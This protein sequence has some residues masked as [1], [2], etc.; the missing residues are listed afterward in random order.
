MRAMVC[1]A[2]VGLVAVGA[3]VAPELAEARKAFAEAKAG[4]EG[5]REEAVGKAVAAYEGELRILLA[6]VRQRGDLDYVTAIQG[7][8]KRLETDRSAPSKPAAKRME[9][10]R[11]AQWGARQA[12][13]KAGKE[14]DAKVGKLVAEYTATL[15]ALEKRFVKDNRIEDAKMAREEREGVAAQGRLKVLSGPAFE[16]TKWTK[17][18]LVYNDMRR[19]WGAIPPRFEGWSVTRTARAAGKPWKV[20]TVGCGDIY[21]LVPEREASQME[22]W[23]RV[24][25]VTAVYGAEY[26][27]TWHV[28]RK[29]GPGAEIPGGMGEAALLLAPAITH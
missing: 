19:A 18:A 10:L 13:D 2:L 8:L 24:T 16:V 7:E 1:A 6:N 14:R 27:F 29:P 12:E 15:E 9:H 17:G 26:S 20:E 23:D 21:V 25:S 22:G 4:I 28:F 3:D 5:E 11:T